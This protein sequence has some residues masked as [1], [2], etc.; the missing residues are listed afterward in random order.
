M[1][2]YRST[3]CTLK[4]TNPHKLD[5]LSEII[6]EYGRVV[7]LYID[8]F[9]EKS[10]Y[11]HNNDLL[12]PVIESIPPTWLG[13][14][15]KRD[16]AREAL[17]NIRSITNRPG[18]PQKKPNYKGRSMTL[19]FDTAY[20]TDSK[21]TDSFD[22]W[23]RLRGVGKY[24]DTG[25]GICIAFPIKFHKH[26]NQLSAK[27]RRVNTIHVYRDS[28]QFI[29]EL[30]TGEKRTKGKQVGVYTNG[31]T[32]ATI[33]DGTKYGTDIGRYVDRVQRCVPG[34]KGH[35]KAQRALKQRL[36]EVVKE[37]GRKH[38][39]LFVLERAKPK[40]DAI[41]GRCSPE[42]KQRSLG[43]WA[44]TY[45]L[46]RF[47]RECE[48][49]RSRF[50]ST[51]PVYTKTCCSACGSTE[52]SNLSGETFL[53][54]T[55]G[56]RSKAAVNVAQNTLDRYLSGPYGARFKPGRSGKRGQGTVFVQSPISQKQGSTKGLQE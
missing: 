55:C 5:I 30:E 27:G 44:Y 24:S 4:Y 56:H 2:V 34:S 20:L 9:W 54:T 43:I 40:K 28:V 10:R 32:L 26:F 50:R 16:A 15:F 47:H 49:R 37:I 14:K 31:E 1:K 48:M 45:W 13:Y 25:E 52:R 22:A 51:A 33:S 3:R 7:R 21:K 11:L 17:R 42:N 39:K 8:L 46:E 29:F 19:H 35:R 6:D 12:K 23:F 41:G 53:C 36:N 18:T 38:V